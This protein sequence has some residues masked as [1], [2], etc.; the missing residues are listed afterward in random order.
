MVF[1]IPQDYWKMKL[2][3]KFRNERKNR[4]VRG[5]TNERKVKVQK[6]SSGRL[7]PQSRQPGEDTESIATHIN[8]RQIGRWMQQ[9]SS[10]QSPDWKKVQGLMQVTFLTRRDDI[11]MMVREVKEKYPFLFSAADV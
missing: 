2:S 11:K 10:K 5:Q 1:L 8:F 4:P 3:D 6:T 7:V 9:E